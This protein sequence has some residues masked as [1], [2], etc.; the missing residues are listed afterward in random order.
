MVWIPILNLFYS[1][2]NGKYW[3]LYILGH[4]FLWS[5]SICWSYFFDVAQLP[6][7]TQDHLQIFNIEAKAKMKS[8]QMPEQVRFL[9]SISNIYAIGG[10]K[11]KLSLCVLCFN[12]LLLDNMHLMIFDRSFFGNGLPLR[13]WVWWHSPRY[14]IGQL[15][16]RS[17]C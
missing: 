14:I 15:K 6:G 1:S 16:V 8:H 17:R 10:C 9:L 4:L 13:C 12:L 7:T 11:Y 3:N 2:V 5:S